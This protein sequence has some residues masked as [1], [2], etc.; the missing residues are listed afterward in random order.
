ML[1]SA[2][3]Y[4]FLPGF[5]SGVFISV[6]SAAVGQL[7]PVDKLGARIGTFFLP[8][9]VATLVGTPIGGAFV[10]VGTKTEYHHV[11]I[12]AVCLLVIYHCVYTCGADFCWLIFP[13]RHDCIWQCSP[14]RREAV[15][16]QGSQGEMVDG[17]RSKQSL[18]F[19]TFGGMRVP[20]HV[21]YYIYVD[22]K[23]AL[24]G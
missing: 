6:S 7:S 18:C 9:A 24:P 3:A 17:F 1:A 10:K 21:C 4:L 11:A 12:F 2:Y 22:R 23:D 20:L 13:G 5:F 19:G 16:L 15:M 14:I 8:T